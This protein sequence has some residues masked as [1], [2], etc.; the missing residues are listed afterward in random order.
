MWRHRTV[1]TW[2]RSVTRTL[3]CDWTTETNEMA[4]CQVV[5]DNM[6][7]WAC[8]KCSQKTAKQNYPGSFTFYDTWSGNKVS[9]FYNAPRAHMRQLIT[10]QKISE[11]HGNKDL[12]YDRYGQWQHYSSQHKTIISSDLWHISHDS[13]LTQ[14]ATKINSSQVFTWRRIPTQAWS[15]AGNRRHDRIMTTVCVRWSRNGKNRKESGNENTAA[16]SVMVN[17]Q[18]FNGYS[19]QRANIKGVR[20]VGAKGHSPTHLADKVSFRPAITCQ[21]YQLITHSFA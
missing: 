20:I 16:S 10:C 19:S 13:L 11:P 7:S 18:S 21:D 1:L 17:F 8:S 12:L 6:S 3:R 15:R 5:T 2:Q 14:A 4:E 9:L